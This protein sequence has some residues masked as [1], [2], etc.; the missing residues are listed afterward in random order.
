M[1]AN[2]YRMN[3]EKLNNYKKDD[4]TTYGVNQKSDWPT[5]LDQVNA[6]SNE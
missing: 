6:N 4:A 3:P 2:A 1:V 5:D